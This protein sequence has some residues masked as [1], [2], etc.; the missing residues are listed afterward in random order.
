MLLDSQGRVIEYVRISLTEA[1]NFCCPYCRDE[2]ITA[3]S[4]YNL[5]SVEEWMIILES[6]YKLGI[7]A[8]RLTGGE[9]LL[10]GPIME[11]LKGLQE[12]QW[13]EDISMTTN[14]SLL[15]EYAKELKE[16]GLHRLNISLDAIDE[17]EFAKKVGRSHQLHAVIEGIEA[18]IAEG[19]DPIKI[20]TVLMEPMSDESVRNLLAYVKKWPVVWRFIEYMPFQGNRFRGPTYDEW[21]E[22]I[23]RI[24]GEPL[25]SSNEVR[26]FGPATYVKLPWGKEMGFIFPM[27]HSYCDSCNRIRITSDGKIRLCLLRDEEIDLRGLVRA[28]L[29]GDELGE[30]IRHAMGMRQ[31]EHDGFDMQDLERKMWTIGG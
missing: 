11:L 26:G 22:Q 9:P 13:F 15:G 7:K 14:G 3:S 16:K 5:V 23:E 25:V 24:V 2:E 21:R 19:F 18:A 30:H 28:G 6:F 17:E 8:V 10:Y 27:T 1:C 20:N 4:Q 31:K 29:R 12:K